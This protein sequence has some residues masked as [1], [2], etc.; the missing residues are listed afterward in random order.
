MADITLVPPVRLA[1][2]NGLGRFSGIAGEAI[3]PEGASTC[4]CYIAADGL[5][6]LT[7]STVAVGG[8]FDG[9]AVTKVGAGDP[10]TIFQQG[11]RIY[12]GA[13]GLDIGAFVYPSD[14]AG[15]LSDASIPTPVLEAPIGKAISA[16]VIE[17]TRMDR[18]PALNP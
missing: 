4:A 5:V 9:I 11:Y 2:V 17:I 15:M 7:V 14:T 18:P 6:Y 10:I 12:I 13:H 16:T 1:S 3:D 8:Q